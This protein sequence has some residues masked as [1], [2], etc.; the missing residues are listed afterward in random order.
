M[1]QPHPY[2]DDIDRGQE[3]ERDERTPRWK[4]VLGVLVAAIV[5]VV[6]V[7]LHLAG[8]VGPGAH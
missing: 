4:A 1:T 8:I 5:I 2:P 3:P 7:Y 6:V